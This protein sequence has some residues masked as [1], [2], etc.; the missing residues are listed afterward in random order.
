MDI[1]I[2]KLFQIIFL[3]LIF[4]GY[5]YDHPGPPEA[6]YC[7]RQSCSHCETVIFIYF[8]VFN[9]SLFLLSFSVLSLSLQMQLF[10]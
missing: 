10:T 6:Q 7:F 1:K 3:M 5:S 4:K 9:I 8:L 2:Q